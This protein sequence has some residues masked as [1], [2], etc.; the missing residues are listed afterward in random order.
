MVRIVVILNG[1]EYWYLVCV[2][3]S[4]NCGPKML[5]LD[6]IRTMWVVHQIK[7]IHTIER[8]MSMT[9]VVLFDNASKDVFACT[10]KPVLSDLLHIRHGQNL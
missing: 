6:L 7:H 1:P 2:L 8:C 9:L 3:A 4:C 5:L 10:K